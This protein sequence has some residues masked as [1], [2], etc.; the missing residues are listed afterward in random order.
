MSARLR[1]KRENVR[2]R[3]IWILWIAV[4]IGS[5]ILISIGD[6]GLLKML[7]IQRDRDQI[8]GQVDDIKQEIGRIETKIEKIQTDSAYIEKEARER[9]GM[10]KPGEKIYRTVP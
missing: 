3:L 1:T 7:K 9:L 6:Y 4:A 10:S 8:L 2:S 5:I